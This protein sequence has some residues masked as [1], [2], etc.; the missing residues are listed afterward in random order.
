MMSAALA[1]CAET[2][3]ADART[4]CGVV[5]GLFF[6]SFL[7]VASAGATPDLE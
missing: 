2:A 3:G 7:G 4:A 1:P 5:G 6:V